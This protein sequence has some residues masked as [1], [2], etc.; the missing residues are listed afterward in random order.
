MNVFE[1][2]IFD[3]QEFDLIASLRFDEM[4]PEVYS[5][6]KILFQTLKKLSKLLFAGATNMSILRSHASFNWTRIC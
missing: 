5:A 4:L 6:I 2:R 1:Y 3:K